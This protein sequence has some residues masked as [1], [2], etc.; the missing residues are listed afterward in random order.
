MAVY[1]TDTYL[2]PQMIK[3]VVALD[4]MSIS[5]E[6]NIWSQTMCQSI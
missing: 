4:E 3:P 1:P 6:F 5:L 2:E